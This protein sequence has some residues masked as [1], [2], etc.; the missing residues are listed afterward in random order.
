MP[1]RSVESSLR[2]WCFRL[3][4]GRRVRRYGFR[5]SGLLRVKFVGERR[6]GGR[7]VF[8]V[9]DLLGKP[10]FKNSAIAAPSLSVICL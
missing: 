2:S 10:P 8:Q 7:V 4:F 1:W 5:D 6:K 3:W 9:A